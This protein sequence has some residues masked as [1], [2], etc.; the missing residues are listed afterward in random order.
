MIYDIASYRNQKVNPAKAAS[1][2]MQSVTSTI[3]FD[4][5]QFLDQL[6]ETHDRYKQINDEQNSLY[7]RMKN[8]LYKINPDLFNRYSWCEVEK[9][10]ISLAIAYERGLIDGQK[11]SKQA[12]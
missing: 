6:I 7:M 8:I 9:N 10:R 12:Y 4:S 3:E 2:E 5:F 11:R 1:D